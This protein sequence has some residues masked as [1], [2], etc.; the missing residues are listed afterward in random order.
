MQDYQFILS[1][2]SWS[3]MVDDPSASDGKA[4]RMPGD[5]HAWAVRCH[6]S[7]DFNYGNP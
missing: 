2:P 3:A 6:F 7:A 5:H 1:K 4:I